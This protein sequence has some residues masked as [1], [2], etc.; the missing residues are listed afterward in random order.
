M[1]ST[2]NKHSHF[3]QMLSAAVVCSILSIFHPVYGS[4][5]NGH[6]EPL[7]SNAFTKIPV[8]ELDSFP[9]PQ[10]FYMNY[11]YP[12]VPVVFKGGAKSSPAFSRWTDDY[13]MSLPESKETFVDVENKKVENRSLG[14]STMSFEDFVKQYKKI[15]GYL[16]TD[17]PNFLG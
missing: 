4:H 5:R 6:L 2:E 16:V 11:V 1:I 15:D 12:S 9:T 14:G 13:L 10:E 17:V 7:A 8:K 3:Q